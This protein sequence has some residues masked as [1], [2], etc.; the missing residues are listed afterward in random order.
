MKIFKKSELFSF[1]FLNNFI[2]EHQ[3]LLKLFGLEEI[4]EADENVKKRKLTKKFWRVAQWV[5][6]LYL[7]NSGHKLN[8][9]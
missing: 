8:V 9:H 7:L 5:K 1:I 4:F 3:S 2:R 6:A